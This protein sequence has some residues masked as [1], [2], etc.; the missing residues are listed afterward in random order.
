MSSYDARMTS[1][2][3]PG[4]DHPSERRLRH[5]DGAPG[6]PTLFFMRLQVAQGTCE[7]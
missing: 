2:Q 4:A 6:G 5:D 1:A 3:S 7:P